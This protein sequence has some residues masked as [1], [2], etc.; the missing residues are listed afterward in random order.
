MKSIKYALKIDNVFPTTEPREYV[1]AANSLD[2][3]VPT[4]NLEADKATAE[5]SCASKYRSR[6]FV[7]R[8]QLAARLGVHDWEKL[9][10]QPILIDLEFAVPS[11]VPCHTDNIND[12]IDYSDVVA[13]LSH[14]AIAKHYEL[15]EAMAESMA[16][17]IHQRYGVPWLQLRLT[18]L[19]PFPGAEVGIVIER[20]RHECL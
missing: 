2:V 17:L 3:G 9:D 19:N 7:R 18:K 1:P 10:L 4:F 20:K 6:I 16:N 8:L 11:E 5:D 13:A 12:A 14:L 15:V